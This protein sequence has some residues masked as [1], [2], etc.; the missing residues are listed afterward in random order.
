M[1]NPLTKE[2]RKRKVSDLNVMIIKIICIMHAKC[3]MTKK[4]KYQ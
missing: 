4:T 2:K 1:E 3:D